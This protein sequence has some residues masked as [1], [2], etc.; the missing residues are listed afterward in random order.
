M[1]F[2]YPICNVQKPF[3]MYHNE[4]FM[5]AYQIIAV[6]LNILVDV[7]N[8]YLSVP[9][10]VLSRASCIILLKREVAKS[11]LNFSAIPTQWSKFK[12]S[13]VSPRFQLFAVI[14]TL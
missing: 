14:T 13:N 5:H 8:Y 6:T 4:H 7:R 9:S 12:H 2:L 10:T 11:V 3:K 1:N